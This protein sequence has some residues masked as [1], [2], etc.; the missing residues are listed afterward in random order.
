M[1][2][3]FEQAN[4]PNKVTN[5][6]IENPKTP[7]KKTKSS[8]SQATTKDHKKREALTWTSKDTQKL[9]RKELYLLKNKKKG[10]PKPKLKD[11]KITPKKTHTKNKRTQIK[12]IKNKGKMQGNSKSKELN[13][14]SKK[15]QKNTL[16]TQ[17]LN[18]N[19]SQK[20]G[21]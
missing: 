11:Q 1:K 21:K 3:V 15:T 16:K 20:A 8:T 2:I 6:I 5:V 4:T 12:V 18:K 9:V 17:G 7:R 14:K 13:K 10:P 19:K